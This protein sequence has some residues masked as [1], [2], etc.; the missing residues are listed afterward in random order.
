MKSA[1]FRVLCEIKEK[2]GLGI[3]SSQEE[4]PVDLQL[5]SFNNM[6]LAEGVA[7]PEQ[8]LK[9]MRCPRST[10]LNFPTVA[11]N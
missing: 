10:P 1:L 7:G 6:F 4:E 3:Q 2:T 8:G 11:A 9:G 5:M